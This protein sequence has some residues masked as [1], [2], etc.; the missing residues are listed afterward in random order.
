MVMVPV[1]VPPTDKVDADVALV[2]TPPVKLTF[3]VTDR[4]PPV[5]FN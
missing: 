1:H 2:I 5:K 4:F 3:P